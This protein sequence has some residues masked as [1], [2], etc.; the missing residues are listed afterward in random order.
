MD[1]PLAIKR[2]RISKIHSQL[3]DEIIQDFR[4][5][6]PRSRQERDNS[7]WFVNLFLIS[8]LMYTGPDNVPHNA[9]LKIRR[10]TVWESS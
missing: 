3:K 4:R 5:F 7:S 1:V 2:A 6:H 9:Y 10:R 8:V